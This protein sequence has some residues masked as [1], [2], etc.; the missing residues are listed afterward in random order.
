M[1]DG[2]DTTQTWTA[3]DSGRLVLPGR[4][5][6]QRT[7]SAEVVVAACTNASASEI[8]DLGNVTR[9][10]S[11][12]KDPAS[13]QCLYFN[14]TVLGLQPCLREPAICY[15]TRCANSALVFQLWQAS[16]QA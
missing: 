1:Y 8:W 4:L 2:P 9:T 6:L 5:C 15:I 10:L 14:G 13:G 3:E 11:Q 12:I 16:E 7:G